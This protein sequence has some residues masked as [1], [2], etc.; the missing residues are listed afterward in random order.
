MII[1]MRHGG[2]LD[3][4]SSETNYIM[5]NLLETGKQFEIPKNIDKL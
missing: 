2:V 4:K 5:N 3:Q 1:Y